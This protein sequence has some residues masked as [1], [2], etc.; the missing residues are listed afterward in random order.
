MTV[1]AHFVDPSNNKNKCYVLETTE[2]QGSHTAERI[3]DRL[4]NIC[5]EWSILDKV[6]GLVSD[7]CNL[8]RK[9]G[10]DFS[11]GEHNSCKS[12]MI[13]SSL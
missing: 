1:T 2:F 6:S 10:S 5:I 7:T 4:E 9:V 11:K 3:V 8:M 12:T 13:Y